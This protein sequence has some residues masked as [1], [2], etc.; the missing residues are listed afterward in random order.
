MTTK[1][2]ISLSALGVI[3]LL[4]PSFT[5]G[6]SLLLAL[7]KRQT[8]RAYSNKKLSLQLLSN[9]LW[10][11]G[12]INR[13]NGPFGVLGRTAATASNS[14]EI[15]IFVAL[16]EG[17]YLYV[18]SSHSLSLVVAGDFRE[19]AIGKGQAGAGKNAPVRL[20]YV[21]DIDKFSTAG[22]QEPGLKD[23]DIQKSYYFTDTGLIAGNVYLFAASHGLGAWFHNCDK[24]GL[25]TKLKLKNNQRVLFGQTVGY[26]LQKNRRK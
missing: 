25:F 6:R 11:A 22:F 20:I 13:K 21:V 15:D 24:T 8:C 4:K 3:Q 26:P 10:A 7:Q 1:K 19:M 14:Q 17:I 18:A 12:G 16:Q 2:S 5:S 23:S 9:L